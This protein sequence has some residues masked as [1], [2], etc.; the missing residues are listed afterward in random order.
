MWEGKNVMHFSTVS[1]TVSRL[2]P[3]STHCG[4]LPRDICKADTEYL[5]RCI[6]AAF[7]AFAGIQLVTDQELTG[8]TALE[9]ADIF[10]EAHDFV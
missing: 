4:I 5:L 8:I 7:A 3:K 10:N 6:L 2:Q 1:V 9:Y